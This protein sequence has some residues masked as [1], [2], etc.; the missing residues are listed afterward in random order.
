MKAKVFFKKV[1]RF[2]SMYRLWKINIKHCAKVKA[3]VCETRVLMAGGG[4]Y[5]W[6]SMWILWRPA[7]NKSM[8]GK[9]CIY[10]SVTKRGWQ[11]EKFKNIF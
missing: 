8:Y 3:H 4:G 7:T 9:H 1:A 10:G 5:L 11:D 6:Q 2:V